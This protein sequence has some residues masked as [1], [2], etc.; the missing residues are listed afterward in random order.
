VTGIARRRI[1]IGA[2]LLLSAALLC[3]YFVW[4]GGR[5]QHARTVI[6]SA[7]VVPCLKDGDIICRLGDKLWSSFV[8][9]M[10]PDDR[11]FSHLGIARIR[12]GNVS[13]INAECL[14]REREERVNDVPLPEFL[15]IAKA[16]G[17]Y[18]ANFMN[19][20]AISDGAARYLGRPFDWKF[21]AGD[22]AEIYCTE[23]LH[24]VIKNAAPEFGLETKSVSGFGVTVI[25]LE[26]VSKSKDFDEVL[27]I[28]NASSQ[29]TLREMEE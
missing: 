1:I 29:L 21:D 20:T 26:A 4:N 6:D 24:V 25:P 5:E 8:K 14:L 23:L 9:Y 10:S 15:K 2:P 7:K 13:V 17:V 18:R 22:D 27:Y 12:N 19:G 16:V 11:R 28:G 3:A